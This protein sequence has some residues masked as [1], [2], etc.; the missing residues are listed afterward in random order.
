LA[1]RPLSG[2]R[3]RSPAKVDHFRSTT[4][5]CFAN[6]R[7]RAGRI[8]MPDWSIKIVPSKSQ[9]AGVLAE[10]VA[11]VAGAKP[12]TFDVQQGDLVSWNNTTPEEHWP[13]PV[14]SQSAAP[15]IPLPPGSPVLTSGS[16]RA[17][18]S[19]DAYNV[20]AATG[21]TIF[22]CCR[23]HPAERGRLVVVP[24]GESSE[25]GPTV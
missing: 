21:T 4:K 7:L 15:A 17:A 19:S 14:A 12:G 2:E 23:L 22:Y 6:I 13:W 25:D 20:A 3:S 11:D 24:F 18:T 8:A 1:T 10:F 9:V 5:N 16:V